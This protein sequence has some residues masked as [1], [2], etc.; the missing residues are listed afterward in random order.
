MLYSLLEQLLRLARY[1][2]TSR[3]RIRDLPPLRV[4]ALFL[5][6][7]LARAVYRSRVCVH[8]YV[9]TCGF[10]FRR[11]FNAAETES[12]GERRE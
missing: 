3:S 5:G 8:V 2:A 12:G 7:L 9:I 6:I 10:R 4:A 11:R 1:R